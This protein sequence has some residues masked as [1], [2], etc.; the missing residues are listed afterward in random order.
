V[1]AHHRQSGTAGSIDDDF[2]FEKVACEDDFE[3]RTVW[4][5]VQP[6]RHLFIEV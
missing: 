4:G 5:R 6:Q 3:T 1:E 2:A